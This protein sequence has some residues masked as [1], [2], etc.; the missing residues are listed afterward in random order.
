MKQL[1]TMPFVDRSRIDISQVHFF[2]QPRTKRTPE[3]EL[4]FIVEAIAT[5]FT[6]DKQAADAARGRRR[7]TA[8]LALPPVRKGSRATISD[9]DDDIMDDTELAAMESKQAG[10]ADLSRRL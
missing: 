6:K 2:V 1:L 3:K 7:S 8:A 5:S 9:D 4:S 10:K